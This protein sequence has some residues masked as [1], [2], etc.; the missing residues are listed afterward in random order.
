MAKLLEVLEEE[1]R[2]PDED[3]WNTASGTVYSSSSLS[4]GDSYFDKANNLTIMKEIEMDPSVYI[5]AERL[6][7]I[8]QYMKEGIR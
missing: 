7:A 5:D 4:S 1:D 8:V 2:I 3:E 6:E